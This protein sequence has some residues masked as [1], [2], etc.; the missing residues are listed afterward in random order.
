MVLEL[1]VWGPGFGLPSVDPE[2]IAAI[3]Y[4]QQTLRDGAWAVVAAHDVSLS[5]NKAFPALRNG[6]TWI[7]GFHAIVQYLQKHSAIE[8]KL[9]EELSER[10]RADIIAYT[11]FLRANALPLVDLNL[12]VSSA[13]YYSATSPAFTTLLPAHLNYT[14]PGAR[15][16]AARL[17]TQHLGLNDLDL[18]T[19]A[20]NE[21]V[22]EDSFSAAKRNAGIQEQGPAPYRNSLIFGKGR[23]LRGFLRQPEYAER[24]KLAAVADDCL[25]P[26]DALLEEKEF[27][28]KS[29]HPTT[30]DCL[31]FGY[32]A[33]MLY[34]DMP[35]PWLSDHIRTRYLHLEEYINRM[36]SLTVGAES[37]KPSDFMALNDLRR[38]PELITQG[39][40][41]LGLLLPWAPSAPVTATGAISNIAHNITAMIPGL[42]RWILPSPII[43]PPGKKLYAPSEPLIH[44]F[45][46][47]LASVAVGILGA[48]YYVQA[49]PNPYDKIFR[50]EEVFERSMNRF[51]G[52]GNAEGFLSALGT[53]YTQEME[54]E[55]QAELQSR[56]ETAQTEPVVEAGFTYSGVEGKVGEKGE[57][58]IP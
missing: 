57:P 55:R 20:D 1:H 3:A 44:G 32:L 4:A 27:L 30:L 8:R 19:F 36:R 47:F 33:L 21:G 34:P 22:V 23:G 16:E 53:Q 49:H 45:S 7:S 9:D 43:P 58:G 38:S 13:N 24:F 31:A 42:N 41:E 14:V 28:V 17:R 18:D 51:G 37:P 39:R 54:W 2:C 29:D 5:P 15:R 6:P 35:S 26:L 10:R 46:T 50:N 56:S 48:A 52:L 40:R 25:A 11:S 12:Y